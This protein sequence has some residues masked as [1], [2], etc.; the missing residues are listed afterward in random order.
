ME[1]VSFV[2][3]LKMQHDGVGWSCSVRVSSFLSCAS[4]QTCSSVTLTFT[5]TCVRLKANFLLIVMILCRAAC[6]RLLST[7]RLSPSLS[8]KT[9]WMEKRELSSSRF[10]P[11]RLRGVIFTEGCGQAGCR[12][13]SSDDHST[14]RSLSSRGVKWKRRAVE[15]LLWCTPQ[16]KDTSKLVKQR[17]WGQMWFLILNHCRQV[18][19]DQ[20]FYLNAAHSQSLHRP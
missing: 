7:T 18:T 13:A 8:Q 12:Q 20:S 11:S 15:L 4:L 2:R 14:C 19:S 3:S 16:E 17:V 9:D 5:D 6:S 10:Q 1:C